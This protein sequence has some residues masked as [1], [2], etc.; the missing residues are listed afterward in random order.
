MIIKSFEIKNKINKKT[1]FYLLYGPNTGLL[2]NTIENFLKP[3]FSKNIFRYEESEIINNIDVFKLNIFNKSFFENEKL[4]IIDRSSDKIYNLIKEIIE[5]NPDDIK[6]IIKST[7]LEKKSK[8]RNFFEKNKEVVIIPHYEDNYQTLSLLTENFLK[9]KKII[10]SKEV[11]NIIIGKARGNREVL[12]NEL[13]KIY[14]L[15]RTR[16]TISQEQ[17]IKLTNLIENYDISELVNEC[18][19]KNKNKTIKILNENNLTFEDNIIIMKSF[20]NKLKRLQKLKEEILSNKN[21][22]NAI[23]SFRPSIF[24]KEKEIVKK[25]LNVLSIKKIRDLIKEI[26]YLELLLKKNSQISNQILSNF[27]FRNIE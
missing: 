22:D 10:L 17:I 14:F 19:I 12:K 2:E 25:Q 4:I 1:N 18:L 8:L 26:N 23:S 24:W 3:I 6:I 15:S 11:I 7:N 13:E 5:L 20:L 21:V 27:I 16:S 9:E